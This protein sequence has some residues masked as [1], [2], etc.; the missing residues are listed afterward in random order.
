M[1]EL[2][3]ELTTKYQ[4]ILKKKNIKEDELNGEDEEETVFLAGRYKGRCRNYGN[5]GH[6]ALQYIDRKEEDNTNMNHSDNK[7]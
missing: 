6:K 5:F 1:F 4:R 2:R 3:D 7:N